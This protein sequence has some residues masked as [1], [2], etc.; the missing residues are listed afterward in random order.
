MRHKGHGGTHLGGLHTYPDQCYQLVTSCTDGS[1]TSSWPFQLLFLHCGE[2]AA[3]GLLYRWNHTFTM[4]LTIVACPSGEGGLQAH[5]QPEHLFQEVPYDCRL[6]IAERGRLSAHAQTEP[7]QPFTDLGFAKLSTRNCVKGARK[8]HSLSLELSGAL[9][10][11]HIE[12]PSCNPRGQCFGL[13]AHL[14]ALQIANTER[15]QKLQSGKAMF[16]LGAQL[17]LSRRPAYTGFKVAIEGGTVW[18]WSLLELQLRAQSVRSKGKLPGCG[19]GP[20]CLSGC[21]QYKVAFLRGHF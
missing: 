5:A 18:A 11:A 9:H 16:E 20:L 21:G 13:G 15:L 3:C 12:W 10:I 6:S 2:G 8:G 14:G 19:K 4:A 1:T 17:E 7:L